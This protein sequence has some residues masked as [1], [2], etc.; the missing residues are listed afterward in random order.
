MKKSCGSKFKISV[1]SLPLSF[2]YQVGKIIATTECFQKMYAVS[3]KIVSR[4]FA[5]VEEPFIQLPRFL[6]ACTGQAAI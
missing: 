6:Q 2:L 4:F 3:Q 5:A 1:N